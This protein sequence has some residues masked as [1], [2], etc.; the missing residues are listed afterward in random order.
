MC[1]KCG[2]VGLPNVGKST[3]SNAL[4]QAA[5]A[6]TKNYPFCTIKPNIGEVPIPDPRLQNLARIA[7][8]QDTVSTRMTFIDIAG[9]VKG[10]SRGEGLGNK[11]L[12]NIREM[13]AVTYVLRCFDDDITHVDGRIN[14]V[15]DSETVET[16]L[17]M[18]DLESIDRRLRTLE[19]DDVFYSGT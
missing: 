7:K 15:S 13:D 9:L 6:Q 19:L 14:P 10:A 3:L 11:F 12:A 16:E 2:I 18:S 8:S 4:T 17:M 1:F 5:Q